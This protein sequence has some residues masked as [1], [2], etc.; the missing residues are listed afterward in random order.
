[1]VFHKGKGT[2]KPSDLLEKG[3]DT[4][5]MSPEE[6]IK[7]KKEIQQGFRNGMLRLARAVV[8]ANPGTTK[9]KH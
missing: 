9:Q 4:S 1:M 3:D 6:Q 8:D 2:K 7:R 5:N